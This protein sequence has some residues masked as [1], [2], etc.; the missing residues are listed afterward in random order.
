M[1]MTTSSALWSRRRLDAVLWHLMRPLRAEGSESVPAVVCAFCA[2]SLAES[3][4]FATSLAESVVSS[5]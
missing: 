2:T 5:L 1:H 4:F 3:M